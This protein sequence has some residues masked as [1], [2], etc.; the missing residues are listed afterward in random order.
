MPGRGSRTEFFSDLA[1]DPSI[2]ITRRIVERVYAGSS[3]SFFPLPRG[4]FVRFRFESESRETRDDL[5]EVESAPLRPPWRTLMRLPASGRSISLTFNQIKRPFL[6]R[7]RFTRSHTRARSIEGLGGTAQPLHPLFSHR[8][9]N[10][11][12]DPDG[13]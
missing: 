5:D 11:D 12:K 8:R 3:R 9:I 7:A 10:F 13:S 1:S 6:S 2:R 4:I